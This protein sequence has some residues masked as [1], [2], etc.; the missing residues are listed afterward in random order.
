MY[1][2]K[3]IGRS[4]RLS[5]GAK[6]KFSRNTRID[7]AFVLSPFEG[8][9]PFQSQFSVYLTPFRLANVVSQYKK[10]IFIEAYVIESWPLEFRDI[11]ELVCHLSSAV[12]GFIA[13]MCSLGLCAPNVC[14]QSEVDRPI[15]KRAK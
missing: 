15:G 10:F 11:D 7:L 3:S 8:R 1:E 2:V 13:Q 6:E 14:H 5:S 9:C 12:A 4:L